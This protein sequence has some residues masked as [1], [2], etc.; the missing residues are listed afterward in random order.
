MS[1]QGGK[2]MLVKMFAQ[3]VVACVLTLSL[4]VAANSQEINKSDCLYLS[5]LHSTAKGMAYWYDK[6]RGGLETVAGIPY[7]QLA[8]KNCHVGS[9][10]AC[11]KTSVNDKPAYST[12]EARNQDKCLTCH[13]REA[14][15]M[16]IDKEANTVDVHFSNGMSCMDCHTARE[17]HGDGVEYVSMKQPGAMDVNC[18]Q[19]H[20]SPSKIEAH[21]VHGGKLDCKACHVRQVVS[22][23]NCHFE[24]MIKEGKRVA[25]PVSGWLFLMNR[26]GKVTSANMQTFTM[27]GGKTFMIFAPQFSHSVYK[28]A[29]CEDCHATDNVKQV[30]K[31]RIDLTWLN[32]GKMQN[33]KGIIP[34][35]DGVEYN[36]VYED[37]AN[38][39][40]TP[41]P[42]AEVPKV[43]YVGFGSPLT[44]E[45]MIKL[46]QAQV[47]KQ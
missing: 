33:L 5:S 8:C 3:V 17:M 13:A 46:E 40:W 23:T 26:E 39:T 16:K 19:C 30:L 15:I 42:N 38:G 10:D 21:T 11:H 7:A 2:I 41:V 47:T 14:S 4:A 28:G 9:C 44:K 29:K 35:V 34:V 31:G 22:C 37:F 45:Q 24:T 6:A 18:E 20:E 12:K 36:T 32:D 27:K 1:K 25:V 43:Q